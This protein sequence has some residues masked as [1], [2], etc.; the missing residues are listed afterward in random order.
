M[1][2]RRNCARLDARHG[3]RGGIERFRMSA[4]AANHK[5]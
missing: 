4:R 5:A 1:R 3:I 2:R